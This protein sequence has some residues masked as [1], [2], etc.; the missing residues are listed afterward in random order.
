[1]FL[2]NFFYADP[3]QFFFRVLFKV[4]L[5]SW[6]G[7]MTAMVLFHFHFVSVYFLH[8]AFVALCS[9]ALA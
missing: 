5:F 9:L 7:A 3:S 2:P 8:L 1:V 4:I 6:M